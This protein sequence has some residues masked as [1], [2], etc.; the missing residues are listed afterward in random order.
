MVWVFLAI[1]PALL[2]LGGMI[3]HFSPRLPRDGQSK[4]RVPQAH[5]QACS[6]PGEPAEAVW[7]FS[8]RDGMG[9]LASSGRRSV[10]TREE[11]AMEQLASCSQNHRITE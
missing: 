8:P 7:D 9:Q 6:L 2:S 4:G 10:S 3:P 1:L 5:G 11:F